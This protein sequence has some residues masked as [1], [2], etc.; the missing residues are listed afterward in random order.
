MYRLSEYSLAIEKVRCRQ[1][2]LS[3][4]DRLCPKNEVETELH[5]L[6][7]CPMYDHIRDTYFPQIT[8]NH[9]EFENKSNFD[10]KKPSHIYWVKYHRVPSQ[11]QDL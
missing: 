8:Q 5:F 9:K 3:R 7:S 2:W 10:K 11:Q 4:E 1:T 6:T